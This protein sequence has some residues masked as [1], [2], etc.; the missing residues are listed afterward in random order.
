MA[1][2]NAYC[3]GFELLDQGFERVL[4]RLIAGLCLVAALVTALLV[5]AGIWQLASIAACFGAGL[6]LLVLSRQ[7]GFGPGRL[8]VDQGYQLQWVSAAGEHGV[9]TLEAKRLGRLVQISLETTRG[10]HQFITLLPNNPDAR[11]EICAWIVWVSC[12]PEL[13]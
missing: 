2:D 12:A 10:Q 13:A 6:Y 8:T 1:T 5:P 9:L 7:P 11:A 3:I 4:Q